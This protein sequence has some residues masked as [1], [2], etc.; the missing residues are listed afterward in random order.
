M[1]RESNLVE[2]R[3][4]DAQE[5]KKHFE[6]WETFWGRP[7]YGAPREGRIQKE[8]LMKLLHFPETKK[9]Q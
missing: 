7:G 5:Q 1:Q 2:S 3:K 8:N 9:V 4:N 6:N